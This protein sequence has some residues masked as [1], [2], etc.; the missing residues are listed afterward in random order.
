VQYRT[1]DPS[2]RPLCE[3]MC[4]SL[5]EQAERLSVHSARARAG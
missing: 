3:L 4:A 2:L 1:T 5:V